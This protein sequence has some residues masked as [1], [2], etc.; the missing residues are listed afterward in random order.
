MR[1]GLR[2]FYNQS[3]LGGVNYVLN[4]AR[5]LNHLPAGERPEIIFLTAAREANEIALRNRQ[6]A[7]E[8]CPFDKAADLKLDFVFP[9]TQIAEAPFGAPWGGWIPD[10]QCDHY[11]E[12]FSRDEQARRFLQYRTLAEGPAVCIFSSQQA[13]DDTRR[14]LGNEPG[15]ALR[16]FRF[17]AVIDAEHYTRS[18]AALAATRAKFGIPDRYLIVCNQFWKHKNHLVV[19]EA[20]AKAADLDVHVVMTGAM[21]DER[22]P[23]YANLVKQTLGRPDVAGRVTLTGKIDR[24]EQV[25]LMLGAAGVIQPSLFEG[26]STFVEEARALGLASI[27]SDIPVH[28]EQS[29][30]GCTFFNPNDPADLARKLREFQSRAL[31][32]RDFAAIQARQRTYVEACAR[33]FMGIAHD[34]AARFEPARHETVAILAQQLPRVRAEADTGKAV[35]PYIKADYDRYLANVRGMLRPAPEKLAALAGLLCDESNPFADEAINA[36]VL[37]TLAKATPEERRRFMDYQPQSE[38]SHGIWAALAIAKRAMKQPSTQGRHAVAR[39]L[40]RA[41]EFVRSKLPAK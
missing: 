36:V 23:D 4:I 10:W 25:D 3:W 1:I 9:A 40:T 14:I 41:K 32:P 12:L 17:P 38:S 27:L 29:P 16:V 28:R 21:E 34:C 26:W 37:A 30:P 19:A 15:A 39:A 11:P 7:D 31:Q 8:I 13:I 5:M 35:R 20:L 6:L 24:S 22:W 2:L 18:P 33:V